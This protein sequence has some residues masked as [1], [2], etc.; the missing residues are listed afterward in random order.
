MIHHLARSLPPHQWFRGI[1]VAQGMN[2]S[3]YT[4]WLRK[5]TLQTLGRSTAQVPMVF[6]D[7]DIASTDRRAASWL[8]ATHSALSAGLNQFYRSQGL[9]TPRRRAKHAFRLP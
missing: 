3:T 7:F 6:L 8:K 9:E 5:L 2:E 1:A 4:I